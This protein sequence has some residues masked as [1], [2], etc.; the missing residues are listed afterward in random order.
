MPK[1]IERPAL[2]RRHSRSRVR[3]SVVDP[4]SFR[5]FTL[6]QEL[7]PFGAWVGDPL[8]APP[9]DV[10]R[11][12]AESML[13]NSW[14]FVAMEKRWEQLTDLRRAEFTQ[15]RE[16]ELYRDSIRLPMGR[17]FVSVTEQKDFDKI[18]DDVPA[19]VQTRLDEFLEGP[20]RR[21]G[22]KVYYLKPLCVDF[23]DH[24]VLTTR[25]D[26]LSAINKVKQEVFSEYRELAPAW[27][28]VQACRVVADLGLAIPR[29][30]F[31]YFV[32]RRKRALDAYHARLEFKRRKLALGVARNYRKRR[33]APCS[34][35]DVL[36]MTS[37]LDSKQVVHQYCLEQEMSDAERQLLMF[38]AAGV[39]IPWFVALSVSAA[40]AASAAT[41]T[42]SGVMVA[43]PAFV[44][45]MPDANGVLLKI[46]HFDEVDGV[47]H[48]EI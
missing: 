10:S 5:P 3:P 11:S 26:L 16:I 42:A 31:R 21:P 27:R 32:E 12:L 7:E 6:E 20:G 4:R 40:I 45:Q 44:A 18:T 30:L 35:N 24:L 36:E 13:Q 34:F 8:W 46:G 1:T 47:T 33:T 19:C 28:T 38:A 14:A 37:P 17:F 25:E 43:D 2:S 39:A 9:R 41:V 23:C 22:V 29:R 48:V 15:V